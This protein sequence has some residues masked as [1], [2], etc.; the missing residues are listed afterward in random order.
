MAQHYQSDQHP[1]KKSRVPIIVL[2]AVL[3]TALLVAAGITVWAEFFVQPNID[4]PTYQETVQQDVQTEPPTE[5]PAQSYLDTMTERE[6]ISQLFIVK[7]EALEGESGVTA[8][9][10]TTKQ[11][12]A[13]Y[14]VGGVVV[15]AANLEDADQTETMFSTLQSYSKTPLFLAVDEE[16]GD[17]ARCAEMLGT[18]EFEPM[19]YYK[20]D[21]DTVAHDNA[22]TIAQDIRQFGFNLDFAPV[23][24]VWTNPDNTVIADRAYSDDYE[25]AAELVGSAVEGFRDGGVLCTL[26]HFPGHGD[27]YED[28]HDGLAYV[29]DTAEELKNGALLPFQSGI[30]AGADMVMVGH[31]MV[32]DVDP[33]LPATLSPKI[34]PQLLRQ[35]LDYDGVVITDS[36][37]MG[38]ITDNYSNDEIVKGIFDA[39]IDIILAPESLEDYVAA[40]EEGIHDGSL[41]KEQLD[42]KVLRIL[43]LKYEKGIILND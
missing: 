21:G 11:T 2:I 1:R 7:P 8:V 23:A 20:D 17:V 31:L 6:K 27:T 30:D 36:M 42:Q 43:T 3:A 22:Q 32:E 28:S 13:E 39:D 15:L 34:V 18:T 12:L 41:S 25:Q 35:E 14:P 26:K 24:D 29:N 5:S 10:E 33:D 40:I 4:P 38:A 19:Y 9:S 37:G 16:G